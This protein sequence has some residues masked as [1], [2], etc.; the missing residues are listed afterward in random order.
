MVKYNT[1]ILKLLAML[2][3]IPMLPMSSV[4]QSCVQY[5]GSNAMPVHFQVRDARAFRSIQ[6]TLDTPQRAAEFIKYLTSKRVLGPSYRKEMP[7]FEK[8]MTQFLRDLEPVQIENLLRGLALT[9]HRHMGKDF[10]SQLE[11]SIIL[12]SEKINAKQMSSFMSL[13]AKTLSRPSENFLEFWSVRTISQLHEMNPPHLTASLYGLASMGIKPSP[14]WMAAWLKEAQNKIESYNNQSLANTV[15]ALNL[16]RAFESLE[17]FVSK[18][19]EKKWSD[20]KEGL[21]LHRRQLS[22]TV[23]YMDIVLN[24]QIEVLNQFRHDFKE[25][26]DPPQTGSWLEF[27]VQMYLTSKNLKYIEEF[28]TEHGFYV[29]IFVPTQNRIMQIDG[30]GHYVKSE[31]PSGKTFVSRPQD[32]NIDEILRAS[33]YK[34]ERLDV[35]AVRGL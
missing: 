34:V 2:V 3:L 10:L 7:Q 9:Q 29:D 31:T 35:E 1:H 16:L 24:K 30:P 21:A 20:I 5:L 18:V 32:L 13:I 12:N 19:P 14:I 28:Q 25:L 15:Y 27:E 17:T 4:A 23:M 26:V 6:K 33:G 8:T 11:Q 22:L